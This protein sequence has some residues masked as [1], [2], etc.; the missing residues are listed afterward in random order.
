MV[1]HYFAPLLEHEEV[2]SDTYA[3][4]GTRAC[5]EVAVVPSIMNRLIERIN[6]NMRASN[7][8]MN[9]FLLISPRTAP[10][11]PSR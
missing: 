11:F 1:K 8:G 9:V 3:E 6:E 10:M 2:L 5:R 7:I 4:Y